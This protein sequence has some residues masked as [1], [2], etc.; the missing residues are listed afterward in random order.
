M[1]KSGFG[2]AF[3]QVVANM[4]EEERQ[5]TLQSIEEYKRQRPKESA[6]ADSCK[7]SLLEVWAEADK[8]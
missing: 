5:Q 7:A 1:K 3:R 8:E 6:L 2:A 4:T